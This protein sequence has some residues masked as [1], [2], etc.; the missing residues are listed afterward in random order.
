MPQP[1]ALP[2]ALG[3][4]AALALS[5]AA[6]AAAQ[7]PTQPPEIL[8]APSGKVTEKTPITFR[9]RAAAGDATEGHWAATLDSGNF[10]QLELRPSAGD[11][12]V[13]ER[14]VKLHND[15]IFAPQPNNDEI[16]DFAAPT[17]SGRLFPEEVAWRIAFFPDAKPS[18]AGDAATRTPK[19]RFAFEHTYER[20][21]YTGKPGLPSVSTRRIVLNESLG[22]VALTDRRKHVVK[23]WG[24][25]FFGT[26]FFFDREEVWGRG[27]VTNGEPHAHG[28]VA[29]VDYDQDSAAIIAIFGSGRR[30]LGKLR[31]AKG[32][33]LGSTRGALTKAYPRAESYETEEGGLAGYFVEAKDGR[34]TSFGLRRGKVNQI[35]LRLEG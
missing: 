18:K 26:D 25:P 19:A 14:T 17:V 15:P 11:P 34:T 6:P 21:D 4:V 23:V 1:R 29:N 20:R 30:G 16:P 24:D 7:T 13:Y 10:E 12:A 2:C 32:I 3:L 8:A 22:G 5:A 9:I 35:V 31:T 27:T 28:A 33:H